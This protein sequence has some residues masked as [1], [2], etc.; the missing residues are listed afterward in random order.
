MSRARRRWRRSA[1]AATTPTSG[2]RRPSLSPTGGWV[3]GWARGDGGGGWGGF[4]AA[5]RVALRVPCVRAGVGRRPC[6]PPGA[7]I[8]DPP[9]AYVPLS[10]LGCQGGAGRDPRPPVPHPAGAAAVPRQHRH[11]RE[12]RAGGRWVC[13]PPPAPALLAESQE[14]RRQAGHERAT[15]GTQ[16]AGLA[17][18]G[19]GFR[20]CCPAYKPLAPSL[21]PAGESYSDVQE[22]VVPL[23]L[24]Y[25]SLLAT[26][27]NS[28]ANGSLLDLI[29]QVR[30][31][32]MGC[33][34]LRRGAAL[35]LPL[36]GPC[37][38]APCAQSARPGICNA[39]GAA[40][41]ACARRRHPAC[42]HDAGWPAPAH[43]PATRLPLPLR[44]GGHLWAVR[45]AAGHQ[46]GVHQAHRGGR[47]PPEPRPPPH[48]HT[49]D[50]YQGPPEPLPHTPPPPGDGRHHQLP[51]R[52]Q[53]RRVGRG[54][55]AGLPAGRAAG[56][57]A[58]AAARHGHDRRRARGGGHLQVRARGGGGVG[59]GGWGWGGGGGV[60]GAAA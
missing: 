41:A 21:P 27:D 14:G 40:S 7:P 50:R 25:D 10:P 34:V 17:A 28:V 47:R 44:P 3:G 54:A 2:C 56:A 18:V 11:Q 42:L 31:C 6:R 23:R 36:L 5:M 60:A 52:G 12:A 37:T 8:S 39:P 51:G 19:W 49:P 48:T 35:P 53:V 1:S 58:A 29:R 59:V 30:A 20:G 16:Q 13:A 57:A 22:M 4:D 45:H 46:A 15:S 24:M 55:A 9:Q 33:S 32:C 43:A 26:G 38:P